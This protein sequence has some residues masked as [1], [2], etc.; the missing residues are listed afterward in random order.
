M[1]PHYT[2][3]QERE[4][5]E[6]AMKWMVDVMVKKTGDEKAD[7]IAVLKAKISYLTT[8]IKTHHEDTNTGRRLRIKEIQD[9]IDALEGK[10]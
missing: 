10:K 2:P 1:C 6:M 8:M 9:E 3:E 4:A 7:N 5:D